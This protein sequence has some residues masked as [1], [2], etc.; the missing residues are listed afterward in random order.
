MPSPKISL[1]AFTK[2]LARAREQ[3]ERHGPTKAWLTEHNFDTL[4]EL[5]RLVSLVRPHND[6]AG[7]AVARMRDLHQMTHDDVVRFC[8]TRGGILWMM[9]DGASYTEILKV[10]PAERYFQSV[11]AETGLRP[12]D[13]RFRPIPGEIL[14]ALTRDYNAN[15]SYAEM[16]RKHQL[17]TSQVQRYLRAAARQG[18]CL[19][20]GTHIDRFR[21]GGA[22]TREQTLKNRARGWR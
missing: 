2:D 8:M 11:V 9:L 19:T 7:I 13:K 15:M 17:S 6:Q 14:L 20:Y 21:G 1:D 3:I 4:D 5:V 10:Y 12:A 16:G 18:L 22:T